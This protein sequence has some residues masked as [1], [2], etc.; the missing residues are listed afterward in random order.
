MNQLQAAR[1]TIELMEERLSLV[2]AV[3]LDPSLEAPYIR[4][5]QN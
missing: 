3:G 4:R 5:N 1:D 2:P